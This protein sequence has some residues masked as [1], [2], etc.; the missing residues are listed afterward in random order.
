MYCKLFML[1]LA[2]ITYWTRRALLPYL[3]G[4]GILDTK[5]CSC[6]LMQPLWI[7]IPK[8]FRKR[9]MFTFANS[10]MAYKS[11]TCWNQ[12]FLS[13]FSRT[14]GAYCS[15]PSLPLIYRQLGY[16]HRPE[17]QG[18]RRTHQRSG[19]LAWW[20]LLSEYKRDNSTLTL[21]TSQL[22]RVNH[23]RQGG[24]RVTSDMGCLSTGHSGS[25]RSVRARMCVHRLGVWMLL[26][27]SH[28]SLTSALKPRLLLLLLLPLLMPL[29]LSNM[30]LLFRAFHQR[31]ATC[32]TRRVVS[33]ELRG[34]SRRGGG[35]VCKPQCPL[36]WGRARVCLWLI[37]C[38]MCHSWCFCVCV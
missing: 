12:C 28:R 15:S 14:N 33:G 7:A 32:K 35:R 5:V 20:L 6:I 22:W 38:Y 31:A 8:M 23:S 19:S 9:E 10:G 18:L 30:S 4:F 17:K 37:G 13:H 36:E 3:K 2:T 29:L 21:I 26:G 16:T 24:G 11:E 25:S 34:G 1:H 27:T